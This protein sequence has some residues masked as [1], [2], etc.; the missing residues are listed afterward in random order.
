MRFWVKDCQCE[1]MGVL[2]HK[3]A[4]EATQDDEGRRVSMS[5]NL[6]P[7]CCAHCGADYKQAEK[8]SNSERQIREAKEARRKP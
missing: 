2:P 1:E 8:E 7:V 5:F 6:G 3:L 4:M